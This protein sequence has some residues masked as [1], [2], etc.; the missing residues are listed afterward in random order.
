MYVEEYYLN[1]FRKIIIVKVG[2]DE[3]LILVDLYP[4]DIGYVEP[5]DI[6]Y[7]IAIDDIEILV[8]PL[9]LE[10]STYF[11]KAEIETLCIQSKSSCQYVSL[12]LYTSYHTLTQFKSKLQE[13]LHKII[14]SIEKC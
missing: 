14:D 7:R 9:K 4:C 13:V 11:D 2:D 12:R 5:Q 8:K 6:T 1:E 3:V 10:N